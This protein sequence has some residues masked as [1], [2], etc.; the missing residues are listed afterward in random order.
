MCIVQK[1]RKICD[2]KITV[3]SGPPTIS[4][5]FLLDF[6][7]PHLQPVVVVGGSCVTFVGGSCVTLVGGSCVTLVGGSSVIPIV[8]LSHFGLWILVRSVPPSQE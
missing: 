4:R 6:F 3:D 7:T 1:Y 5:L 8:G 2:I